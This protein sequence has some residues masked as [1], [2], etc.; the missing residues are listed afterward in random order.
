[1]KNVCFGGKTKD[2][3]FVCSQVMLMVR[4]REWFKRVLHENNEGG[5]GECRFSCSALNES[6]V[7]F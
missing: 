4:Q 2:E 6:I 7:I 1:M 3:H 5:G